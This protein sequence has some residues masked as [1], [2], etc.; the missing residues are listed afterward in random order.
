MFLQEGKVSSKKEGGE[1]GLKVL[2]SK[3][4]C[5][6]A[7]CLDEYDGLVNELEFDST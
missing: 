4:H 6:I 1:W 2:P 3:F 7:N 5:I